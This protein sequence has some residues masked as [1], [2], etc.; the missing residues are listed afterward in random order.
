MKGELCPAKE[1][2][3]ENL[4]DVCFCDTNLTRAPY[5]FKHL[6]IA[7]SVIAESSLRLSRHQLGILE[8]QLRI[9]DG[10]MLILW[11]YF[12]SGTRGLLT[13]DIGET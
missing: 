8:N 12:G 11:I 5:I 6:L 13:V 4:I 1:F 2:V 10:I 3:R 7:M 9:L